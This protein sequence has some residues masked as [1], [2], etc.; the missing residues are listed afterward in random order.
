MRDGLPDHWPAM[1]GGRVGQVNGGIGI[2]FWC[3]GGVIVWRGVHL[4][5]LTL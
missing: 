2:I 4:R 1:L 5:L 3:G